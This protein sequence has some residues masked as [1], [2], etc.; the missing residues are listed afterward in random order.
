MENLVAKVVDTPV[1]EV[2][3]PNDFLVEIFFCNHILIN[4]KG[5]GGAG[6]QQQSCNG[7]TESNAK[8]KCCKACR[9]RMLRRLMI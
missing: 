5:Y 1:V 8:I 7:K 3:N 6:E 9:L 4:R 2:S